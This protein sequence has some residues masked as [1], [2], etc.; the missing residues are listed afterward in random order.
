MFAPLQ[1]ETAHAR[2]AS[3]KG[4]GGS[5]ERARVRGPLAHRASICCIFAPLQHETAHARAA[6]ANRAGGSE[7]RARVRGPLRHKASICCM[8][9][10][11]QHETA[12]ARAASAKGAGGQRGAGAG[13]RAIGS[14]GVHLLHVRVPATRDSARTRG[15]S[16]RSQRQ[17]GAGA[18]SRAVASRGVHLLH[19]RM[20][21]TRDSARTRGVSQGEPAGSEDRARVRGAVGSHGLHLL[22]VRPPATRDSARTRGVSQSSRRQRGAGAGSRAVGSP[23]VHLLHVRMPATRDSARTRGVSQGEPAGSEDRARVR[24]PLAHSAFICCMFALLQHETAHAR[25]ASAKGSRRAVRSGRGFEGR[26]LTRRSSAA[27]SPSC[28]TRQR[29]HARRQPRGAGGQ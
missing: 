13:S 8:F 15:V 29:T 7:E 6:S 16:H 20:P 3:A 17:R 9:A 24:G 23:G 26:W 14:R 12:H 4:A 18:G 5:A 2:A 27:C 19:V 1:H 22:H 21:A 10:S 25:A 28:N 11:L